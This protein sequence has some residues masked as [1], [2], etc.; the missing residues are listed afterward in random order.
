[1]T[2]KQSFRRSLMRTL[3]LFV[4]A[5]A[6]TTPPSPPAATGEPISAIAHTFPVHGKVL[7]DYTPPEKRWQPGHRGV[8]LNASPGQPIRASAPGVV[9][10]AGSIAGMTSVSIMHADGIRTTYQPIDTA[11]E[12][13]DHVAAGQVIGHLV[14]NAKHPE[15]GLHWGALRGKDYLNPLD[16][17]QRRPI[18]LKPVRN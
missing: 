8:D 6:L 7:R 16:L 11:L 13:G 14:V 12:K 3:A 15:P 17:I 18:V 4:L 9:H 1:M 2:T 5:V 10:F